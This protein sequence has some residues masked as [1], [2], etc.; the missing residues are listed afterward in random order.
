MGHSLK[1]D[2]IRYIATSKL[3]P[4]QAQDIDVMQEHHVRPQS[5]H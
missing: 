5:A 4:V 1:N 2:H 3:A